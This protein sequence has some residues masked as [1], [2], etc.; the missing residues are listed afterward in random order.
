MLVKKTPSMFCRVGSSFGRLLVTRR[1]FI[2][3]FKKIFAKRQTLNKS[4]QFAIVAK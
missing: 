3:F 1:F 4:K 2:Y